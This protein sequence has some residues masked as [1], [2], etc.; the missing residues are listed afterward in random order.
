VPPAPTRKSTS[1]SNNQSRA[2][3][4]GRSRSRAKLSGDWFVIHRVHR[5]NQ[6][7]LAVAIA[8]TEHL[9]GCID[10]HLRLKDN[11][12][13][14]NTEGLPPCSCERRFVIWPG[15]KR[16]V[17][18]RP[19]A[20]CRKPPSDYFQVRLLPA[21]RLP[22]FTRDGPSAAVR[23][24]DIRYP[25]LPAGSDRVDVY[26]VHRLY[27]KDVPQA[28]ALPVRTYQRIGYVPISPVFEPDAKAQLVR[29]LFND[30]TNGFG[31]KS[32][33]QHWQLHALRSLP[34]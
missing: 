5:G 19:L 20:E 1:S 7:D 23:F 33:L 11:P 31:L 18:T 17:Q 32:V 26:E 25:L 3:T 27:V 15:G 4:A 22:A 30:L 10:T 34:D 16:G 21:S 6:Q 24:P 2:S 14:L 29:E 13:F 8:Q 12:P 9:L 28:L